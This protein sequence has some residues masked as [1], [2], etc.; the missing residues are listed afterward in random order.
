[1]INKSF[2]GIITFVGFIGKT[3]LDFLASIG[4]IFIFFFEVLK[5][6]FLSTFYWKETLKYLINIG[7]FSIAVVSFTAFFTGAALALQSYNGFSR[8][9]AESAVAAVVALSLTRELAPVLTGI[10]LAGRV[11]GAIAAEMATMKVSEQIDALY[12]MR[13]NPISY[14]IIPRIIAG[15]ITSPILLI[16][17]DVIGV[18]GSYLVAVYKLGFNAETYMIKTLNSVELNDIMT[19]VYKSIIFGLIVCFIGSFYGYRTKDGALGVGRATNSAVVT[20]SIIILLANYIVTS[21][22]T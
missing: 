10:M 7:Y 19:G 13:I 2:L 15:I 14:M 1:M 9:H 3:I 12:T 16:I 20:A 8:M 4:T 21:I 6:V 11:S 22:I 5:T 17:A 18:F